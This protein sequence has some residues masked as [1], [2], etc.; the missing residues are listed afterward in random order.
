MIEKSRV[1]FSFVKKLKRL[2]FFVRKIFKKCLLRIQIVQ[3]VVFVLFR[4]V[5]SHITLFF[6]FFTFHSSI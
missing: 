6:N 5:L 2:I 3:F 4:L 1:R